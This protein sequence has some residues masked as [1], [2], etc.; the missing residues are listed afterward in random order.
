VRGR[1]LHDAGNV[2]LVVAQHLHLGTQFSQVLHQVEGEA[3]VVVDHQYHE[4]T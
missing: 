1:Q 3:V 4:S 2:D